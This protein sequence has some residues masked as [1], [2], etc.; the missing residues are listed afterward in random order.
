[1]APTERKPPPT[2]SCSNPPHPLLNPK[3]TRQLSRQHR[4][5]RVQHGDEADGRG[6]HAAGSALQH[7]RV[8]GTRASNEE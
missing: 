8:G 4:P 1:M 7:L 3:P 6:R 2:H 5:A